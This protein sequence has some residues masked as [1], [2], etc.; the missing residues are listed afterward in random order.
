MFFIFGMGPKT[1]D[2]GP[3]QSRTCTRCG[4]TTVWLRTRTQQRFSLFFIPI[5][6]WGTRTSE[7]CTICGN[8]I[9]V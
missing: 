1:E 2:L 8:A 5:A 9:E 6:R 4:N 7:E 3:G